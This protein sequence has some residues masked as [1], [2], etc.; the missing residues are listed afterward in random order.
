MFTKRIV[1]AVLVSSLLIGSAFA[2]SMSMSGVIKAIDAAKKDLTLQ[3]G[4]TFS[5]PAKFDAK[6][7]KPGEKVTITYEK[8]GD[9]LM[10]SDVEAAK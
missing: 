9:K 7:F 6:K 2:A 10:A 5:V 3:S 4:E 8:K 1:P